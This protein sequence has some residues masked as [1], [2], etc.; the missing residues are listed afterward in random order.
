AAAHRLAMETPEAVG[1]RYIAA[2]EPM[3][4]RDFAMVLADE[5]N[6]RGYRVPTRPL[7]YWVMWTIARVNPT[8]RFALNF[9][10]RVQLVSSDKARRELGWT[11]RPVR[12]SIVDTAESLL[13]YGVVRRASAD[14]QAAPLGAPASA[15][16]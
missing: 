13:R 10:G 6:P 8:V 9:V 1:N 4:M 15:D 12:E 16:R 7:P 14:R 11:T 2:G 5:F 3:W